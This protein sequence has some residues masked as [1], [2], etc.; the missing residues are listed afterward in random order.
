MRDIRVPQSQPREV[1]L[2]DDCIRTQACNGIGGI[3]SML[4]RQANHPA[5]D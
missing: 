3:R 2:G 4:N 1:S 5:T